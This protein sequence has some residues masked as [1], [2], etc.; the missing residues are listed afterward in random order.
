M[1]LL[2]S[3]YQNSFSLNVHGCEVFKGI[4][5]GSENFIFLIS[6]APN[7]RVKFTSDVVFYP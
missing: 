4:M 3:K 7:Y 6:A 1:K 2:F 5:K